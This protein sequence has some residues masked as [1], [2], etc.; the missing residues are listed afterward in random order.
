[1][2]IEQI[3]GITSLA[4]SIGFLLARFLINQKQNRRKKDIIPDDPIRLSAKHIQANKTPQTNQDEH[5]KKLLAK[6][7][8]DHDKVNRLIE[9]E[10]RKNPSGSASGLAKSALDR[11]EWDT[12]R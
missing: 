11:L 6:T 1:M 7:Q 12:K 2:R 9:F 5:Y 3:V 4:A 8:G 10:R